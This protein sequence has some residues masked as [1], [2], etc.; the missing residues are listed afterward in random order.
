MEHP[1]VSHNAPPPPPSLDR[2]MCILL[3][4]HCR[5]LQTCATPR[6]LRFFTLD[7]L[8]QYL[9]SG[10]G[11]IAGAFVHEKHAY[12][13]DLPRYVMLCSFAKLVNCSHNYN[14]IPL[15][16]NEAKWNLGKVATNFKAMQWIQQYHAGVCRGTAMC[17]A[18]ITC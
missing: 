11:G 18:Y 14:E 15:S 9:N 2:C 17:F 1:G 13:F 12:N 16:Q 6:Y 8:L 3:V 4:N 5:L 7:Y 10:P